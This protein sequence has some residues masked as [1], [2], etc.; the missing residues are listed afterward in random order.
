[1][2]IY[3]PNC[4]EF[5][6]GC[7]R[8]TN[9]EKRD[10]MYKIATF[11]ISHFWG[12]PSNMADSLGV[13]LLTWNQ[14]FYRYGSFDFDQLEECINRNLRKLENFREK[15]IFIFS[16]SDEPEIINIFNEFMES[17]KIDS[18]RMKERRSPVAVSKAL[19]LLAP[20]FF[21]LWDDRISKVYNCYYSNNPSEKYIQF[22]KITQDFAIHVKD[23]IDF[24]SYPNKTLLKLIDEYNYAKYT[25]EWI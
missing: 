23:C 3:F 21:P 4:E 14:A 12:D 15:D 9:H 17:L 8:Y 16:E 20:N 25:K 5:L 1:M 2:T 19:H 10:A 13:L 11:L 22:M 24:S 6:R 7:L 18:E